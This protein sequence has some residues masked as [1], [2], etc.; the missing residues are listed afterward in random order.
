MSLIWQF[1][2]FFNFKGFRKFGLTVVISGTLFLKVSLN[3]ALRI[4]DKRSEPQ[5]ERSPN[6][7]LLE[8]TPSKILN[9][10][11]QALFSHQLSHE[12]YDEFRIFEK[13]KYFVFK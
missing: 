13:T 5:S 7:K 4:A 6:R 11:T 1:Y 12:T 8:K 9:E 2:H 10:K 3:F